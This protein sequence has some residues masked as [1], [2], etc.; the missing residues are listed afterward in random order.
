M[1]DKFC[2]VTWNY[3]TKELSCM[4]MKEINELIEDKKIPLSVFASVVK[5]LESMHRYCPVCG[6]GLVGD[7]ITKKAA[8]PPQTEGLAPASPV[9]A[10]SFPCKQC[11]GTGQISNCVCGSCLGEGKIVVRPNINQSKL[12]A[13]EDL[14][15]TVKS[16][17]EE[18]VKKQMEDIDKEV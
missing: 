13:I 11:K 7:T 8:C 15:L 17:T 1:S 16:P 5:V 14:K 12:N 6:A 10:K 9:T 4:K 3:L 18:Q 2:C